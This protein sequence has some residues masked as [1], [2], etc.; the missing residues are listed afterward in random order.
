LTV[1]EGGV[2]RFWSIV[3]DGASHTVCWG[4]VGSSGQ[5]R[6]KTF[7]SEAVAVADAARLVAEKRATG[8]S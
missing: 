4:K 5:E 6:T 1:V 3:V 8:W 7:A 2:D